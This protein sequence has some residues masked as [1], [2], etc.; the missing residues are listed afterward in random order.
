MNNLFVYG[1]LRKGRLEAIVPEISGLLT[2]KTRGY[3]KGK[4][5]DAGNY[6]AATPNGNANQKVYGE[7]VEIEPAKL[8]YVLSILDEYEEFDVNNPS[9]S[10]FIRDIVNV[11]DAKGRQIKSWIYWYNKDVKK[12]K[13]IKGG[14]YRKRKQIIA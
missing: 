2:I 13:Q 6:P 11:K 10:L 12:L 4:L 5:F 3:V 1:T 8:V 14:V 7:V 9:A